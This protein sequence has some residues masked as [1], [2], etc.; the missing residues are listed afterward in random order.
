MAQQEILSAARLWRR[1]RAG[2]ARVVALI[3]ATV[4]VGTANAAEW[5]ASAWEDESTLEFRTT[6]AGNEHWSPVWFVVIDGDVYIRLGSRASARITNNQTAP[7]VGIRIAG[8]Q[9]DNV[10]A[11]AMPDKAQAVDAAMA[12]KYWTDVLARNFSHPLT[13]RLVADT[14]K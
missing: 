4:F 2:W 3:V 5:N 11:E 9:F 12:D 1:R 10:R 6:E 7:L 8:D 13:M 14:S